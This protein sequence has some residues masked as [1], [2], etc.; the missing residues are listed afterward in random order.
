MLPEDSKGRPII[1]LD[2]NG[3]PVLPFDE[4]GNPIIPYDENGKPILLVDETGREA[5]QKTIEGFEYILWF[6]DISLDPNA[7]YMLLGI[8]WTTFQNALNCHPDR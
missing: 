2:E 5:I 1:P 7:E 8:F 4:S 6:E 3:R